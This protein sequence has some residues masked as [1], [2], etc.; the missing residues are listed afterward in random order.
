MLII[1][2]RPVGGATRAPTGRTDFCHGHEQRR[3]GWLTVP[4]QQVRTTPDSFHRTVFLVGKGVLNE[5]GRR[6]HEPISWYDTPLERVSGH[7][8]RR[9]GAE[10]STHQRVDPYISGLARAMAVGAGRIPLI[11]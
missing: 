7:Q 1:D 2:A 4:A 6:M 9:R 8:G 10:E 5:E 11:P 3:I